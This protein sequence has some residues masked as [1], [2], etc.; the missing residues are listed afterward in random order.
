MEA[1]YPTYNLLVH[2]ISS[3][4]PVAHVDSINTLES[5]HRP[6]SGDVLIMYGFRFV[7]IGI[8]QLSKHTPQLWP[9]ASVWIHHPH[10]HLNPWVAFRAG[11]ILRNHCTMNS[12]KGFCPTFKRRIPSLF[13][14]LPM[15][16]VCQRETKTSH[17]RTNCLSSSSRIVT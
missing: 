3:P 14:A 9:T 10:P 4:S 17:R 13:E 7:G 15:Q 1:N 2:F 11:R 6:P 16:K 8:I 5:V 12:L